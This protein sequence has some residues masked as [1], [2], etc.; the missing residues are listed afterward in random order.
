[1]IVGEVEGSHLVN[2]D[3]LWRSIR[4][5]A[6]LPDLRLHDPRHSFAN[7]GACGG[8]SLLVIG[9]LLGHSQASTTQRYVHLSSDPLKAAADRISAAIS[10]AMAEKR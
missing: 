3:R 9:K 6:G 10:A 1:V 5:A 8:D 4:Q 2:I 7:V